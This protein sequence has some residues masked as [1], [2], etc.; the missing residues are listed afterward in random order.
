MPCLSQ[1]PGVPCMPQLSGPSSGFEASDQAA[2]VCVLSSPLLRLCL[3]PF[4]GLRCPL[5]AIWIMQVCPQPEIAAGRP[6]LLREVVDAPVPEVETG[7]RG[8]FPA[9]PR[10]FQEDAAVLRTA[11]SRGVG[12]KPRDSAVSGAA[13]QHAPGCSSSRRECGKTFHCRFRP[14]T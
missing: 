5:W 13:R 9:Y 2:G 10:W 14:R 6:L 7:V 1:L 3:F 8:F 11:F 4:Q 12:A